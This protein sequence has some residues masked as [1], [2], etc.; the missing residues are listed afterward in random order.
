LLSHDT[1]ALRA[2][3]AAFRREVQQLATRLH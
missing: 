2:E 3:V 1:A